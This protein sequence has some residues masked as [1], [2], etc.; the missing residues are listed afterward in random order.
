MCN[1]PCPMPATL[2]S[3]KARSIQWETWSFEKWDWNE[4]HFRVF[5]IYITGIN[6]FFFWC[7]D[8][9]VKDGGKI[10]CACDITFCGFD[11]VVVFFKS[12]TTNGNLYSL[13]KYLNLHSF[14]QLIL[15]LLRNFHEFSIGVT[16]LFWMNHH[17]IS[18][19]RQQSSAL[20][21]PFWL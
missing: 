10:V 1:S 5:F 18:F 19:C 12:P 21:F 7:F 13:M 6:V 2:E 3:W 11:L 8:S 17:F 16:R 9:I 4:I 20:P 14:Y 15:V